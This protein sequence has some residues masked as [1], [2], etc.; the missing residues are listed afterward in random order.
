M[1]NTVTAAELKSQI[2]DDGELALLDVREEGVFGRGHLLFAV[3]VPLSRMELRIR[4]LVPRFATRIVLCDGGGGG[5]NGA[6]GLA[7]T[8]ASRLAGFGYGDISILEDGTAGW[9]DAG[10]ELFGGINV[11]SKAFGEFVEHEYGTE[12]L[13]AEELRQ[14]MDSGGKLVVLDSRPM[15]EYHR[16]NIPTGIDVP[17]AELAL[18]VHDIAPDPDTLVVVNCAGRTRSI[19]GAQSL[20]NAG[21][22]NRILALRN[23]TMGWHLAGYDLE[24][25][26]ERAAPDV[27]AAGLVRATAAAAEVAARFGVAT[28]DNASLEGWRAESDARSLFILDVRSPEE[29]EAGH[30]AGSILAPGGQLVQATDRYVATQG[31]R[32]V[33]VDDNGVRATMT[34]SWLVQMGWRHVA[35][36]EGGLAGAALETGPYKPTVIAPAGGAA[37]AAAGRAERISAAAAKEL[38]AAG[39]AVAVDFATSLEYRAGHIPGAWFA[40]RS[41][42][43]DCLAGIPASSTLVMTSPD[44]VLANYAARDI[45]ALGQVALG[46][47]AAGPVAVKVVAGGTE[48]W[49]AAGYELAEGFENMASENDDLFYRAYDHTENIEDHMRE[50]LSWETGLVAQVERDGTAKFRRFPA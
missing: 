40:V 31:A 2:A 43:A 38:I 29:Y 8:A 28:I 27:S 37:G 11:P 41:R 10:F 6:E 16:M 20:R 42:L 32:L 30:L 9:A 44:G 36:L 3:C 48:A 4:D 35:V 25:G 47:V 34:A 26:A 24:H 22:A 15:A 17:G 1:A 45:E 14:L 50:Y 46:Q 49:R 5:G 19:I 12:S 7:G 21:I 39:E 18:R 13:S 23:G 33:L